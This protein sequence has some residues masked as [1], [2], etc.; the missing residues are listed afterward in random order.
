[1]QP[2]IK[3]DKGKNTVSNSVEGNGFPTSPNTQETHSSPPLTQETKPKGFISRSS[4]SYEW[5]PSPPLKQDW[6]PFEGFVSISSKNSGSYS[7]QEWD[8]SP[9]L[10][11]EWTPKGFVSISS[12]NSGSSGSSGSSASSGS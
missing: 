9:P 4:S 7:P 6:N 8:P 5:T 2:M 1:M 12:K 10:I 3:N 11:Q